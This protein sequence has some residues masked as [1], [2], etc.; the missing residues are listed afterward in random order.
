MSALKY[1][2]AKHSSK[3]TVDAG[4]KELEERIK[5]LSKNQVSLVLN[6]L[7]NPEPETQLGKATR[8]SGLNARRIFS[9]T[10]DVIFGIDD[11][12]GFDKADEGIRIKKFFNPNG[13]AE[14]AN[15]D[16][17]NA[18]TFENVN[19][20][21][22]YSAPRELGSLNTTE[23]KD[24]PFESMKKNRFTAQKQ[25]VPNNIKIFTIL[26]IISLLGSL[27]LIIS[28]KAGF[29]HSILQGIGI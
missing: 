18:K 24:D 27:G 28:D 10:N 29:L 21:R 26:F 16:T 3:I 20:A 1:V 15:T 14:T 2:S 17:G 9:D 6:F 11:G 22:S 13:Q 4:L 23:Y 19:A 7:D 5:T 8:E 25:G 12:D